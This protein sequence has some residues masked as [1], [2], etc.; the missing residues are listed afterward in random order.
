MLEA[1]HDRLRDLCADNGEGSRKTRSAIIEDE[2]F[3]VRALADKFGILKRIDITFDELKLSDP[4]LIIGS[5]HIVELD[6]VEGLMGKTTVP[7]GFGL[8]PKVIT[9]PTVN[10]RDDP[11]V[12]KFRRAVEFV[13]GS[14]LEYLQRWIDANELFHDD[15]KLASVIE[16]SDKRISFGITQPQYDGVLPQF[17]D[18]VGYFEASGW[19]WIRDPEAREFSGSDSHLFFFNYGWGGVLAV[20]VEPRNCFVHDN[21]LLPFDV[22]LCRPD[23]EMEDFLGLY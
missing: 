21:E 19:K 23:E 3:K 7:G 8:V 12:P 2:T 13:A 1:F 22:I 16:W 9:H 14:P 15:V 5:E 10:L 20:D 17:R 6:E 4:T 11:S 18:I